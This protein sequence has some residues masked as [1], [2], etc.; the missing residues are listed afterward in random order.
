MKRPQLA[1]NESSSTKLE[2]FICN[3]LPVSCRY[4]QLE[5]RRHVVVP[6]VILTEGVHNGS[7][8]AFYYPK[9]ELSKTPEAWNH[10][11][12]V[13]Y[14]P[15]ING[16]GISACDPVIVNT[17]KIGVMMNTQWDG[18]NRLTSEAWLDEERTKKIDPRIMAAVEKKEMME[19]STGV[20]IDQ[21]P[22]PGK[23][24]NEDYVGIARNY[25]PDHLALL[26]DQIGAC[27]V[28]DGAGF[29]RNKE[30]EESGF[31]AH[32]RRA[33]AKAGL[34]DNE[35][36][37]SNI[38]NELSRVLREKLKID[39]EKGPWAWVADIYNNFFIYEYDNK[40][41]R[42]GYTSSDLGISLSDDAPVEVRR[43]T[44][45]RTITGDFVGNAQ[46][47]TNNNSMDKTKLVDAIVSNAKGPWKESDRATLLALSESQL[48]SIADGLKEAPASASTPVAPAQ[49]PAQNKVINLEEYV[50]SAPK[51]VQ[52]VLRNGISTYNTQKAGLVKAIMENK[53]NT[54]TSEALNAMSLDQLTAIAKLAEIQKPVA[55]YA[56]QAP[57]ADG[58]STV[59]A[60]AIPT[61]NF[62][63]K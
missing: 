63:K 20:F 52:E 62:E 54:F 44:E 32:L 15:S 2:R 49:A 59:E 24:G 56:G 1:T 19:L 50:S 57:V 55:N 25:R 28:K 41:Y 8:G 3:L 51:E 10:K 60:L 34:V 4:E 14:H 42:L 47:P 12:I 17:Q 48:N 33:L 13:V 43:V 23:W 30:R 7:L 61:M 22:T 38:S 26:P 9:E 18:K 35:L 36:S 58:A 29:M 16:V 21:D 45:Y 53:Q 39:S 37:H 5:D 46:T 31:L 40:L 6:M 27:S 11:P